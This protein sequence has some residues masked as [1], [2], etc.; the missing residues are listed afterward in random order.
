MG[1]A[2]QWQAARVMVL[3]RPNVQADAILQHI[4]SFGDVKKKLYVQMHTLKDYH[5][6]LLTQINGK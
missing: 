4:A 1:G 3:P 6:E 2:V 5:Y